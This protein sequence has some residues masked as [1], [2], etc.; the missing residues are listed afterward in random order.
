MNAFQ[1]KL[2]IILVIMA[3]LTP[4]GIYLPA[5][6]QAE[7]AWG[8]WSIKSVE[9]MIGFLPEGMKKSADLWKA[10][11]PDYNMGDEKSSFAVQAFSYILSGI[12]GIVLC[13]LV[14]IG[15]SKILV[16]KNE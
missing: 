13:I 4:I 12:I 16:K 6:F 14:L 2:L 8:E 15:L 10:P 9:K 11:V 3:I 1:K 5:K 7:D